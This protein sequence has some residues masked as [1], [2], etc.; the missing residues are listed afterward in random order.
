MS[1][2]SFRAPA[3]TLSPIGMCCTW[4]HCVC[5]LAPRRTCARNVDTSGP[6]TCTVCAPTYTP[7]SPQGQA[8]PALLPAR[9]QDVG[10]GGVRA[11]RPQA[12]GGATGIYGFLGVVMNGPAAAASTLILS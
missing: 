11:E 5:G 9:G 2:P 6:L 8:V 7:S 4:Q 1:S 10:C 12:Q 3:V